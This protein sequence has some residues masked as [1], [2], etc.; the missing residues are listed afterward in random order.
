M[1]GEETEEALLKKLQEAQ[2]AIMN[3]E[4]AKDSK[5]DVKNLVDK[6]MINLLK[7]CSMLPRP[8][9]DD[10]QARKVNF[11]T[12]FRQKTLILDMDETLIHS[13]FIKLTGNESN[14]IRDGLILND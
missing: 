7:A 13:R 5:K 6:N 3:D 4:E 1:D 11:G 2:D 8:S 9:K 12:P 10:I 14:Q